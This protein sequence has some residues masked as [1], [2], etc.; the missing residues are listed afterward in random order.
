MKIQSVKEHNRTQKIKWHKAVKNWDYK[1][2]GF[3]NLCFYCFYTPQGL[4]RQK[5][6]VVI[7]DNSHHFRLTK[8]AVK[9]LIQ[10]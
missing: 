6:F 5:G 7:K 3:P 1:K 9:E 2:G 8:K 4:E 10:N